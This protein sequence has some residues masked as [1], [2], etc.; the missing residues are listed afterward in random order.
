MMMASLLWQYKYGMSI[1]DRDGD[2]V[3]NRILPKPR[4]ET[5]S[6]CLVENEGNAFNDDSCFLRKTVHDH[7]FCVSQSCQTVLQFE[8]AVL[9][10]N[11]AVIII[12]Y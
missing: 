6:P 10:A 5:S 2:A 9:E 3:M 11:G 4:A 8:I 12:V 7:V 1:H